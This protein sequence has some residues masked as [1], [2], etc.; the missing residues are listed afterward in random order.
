MLLTTRVR[1]TF[2]V[3]TLILFASSGLIGESAGPDAVLE[4]ASRQVSAFLEQFSDVKCIERVSQSKLSK[5]G[6]ADV[7]EA[8]TYDYFVLLQGSND[9]LLLN[10]S[11]L[12]QK[13]SGKAGRNIPLLI[14][15]GFSTLFLIFHPYYRSG[16]LFDQFANDSI[17][18]QSFMRVHFTHMPG[19]RT[20]AALAVRGREYPLELSGTAWIDPNTGMI[21]RIESGLA[22]D[23][24]DVGLVSLMVTVDYEPV[25]LPGW[26]QTYRFPVV[27]T[28]EVQS[29]R[30]HWRNVHR[31]TNYQRFMVDTQQSVADKNVKQ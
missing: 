9:E 14:T 5:G 31:F 28:V 12:E 21:A 8:S 18:G 16:F 23:M 29:L 1:N 2:V 20:P 27:A 7:S 13:H 15:N 24:R 4:K 10:E 6:H 26:N 19:R 17:D 11:R 25:S 22:N 30:Q 3:V